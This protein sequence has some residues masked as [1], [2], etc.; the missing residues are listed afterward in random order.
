M[1]RIAW[2]AIIGVIIALALVYG[3]YI[4]VVTPTHEHSSIIAATEIILTTR[5]NSYSMTPRCVEA[6]SHGWQEDMLVIAKFTK[7]QSYEYS[8]WHWIYG[9]DT[10]HCMKIWGPDD[11]GNYYIQIARQH[12]GA[13]RILI[14][15]E[16]IIEEP[17]LT[18]DQIGIVGCWNHALLTFTIEW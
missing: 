13:V 8:I 3:G 15:N 12:G 9:R 10:M 11:L 7:G 5:G 14:N 18:V 17:V 6:G 1:K 16:L 4:Q 2:I